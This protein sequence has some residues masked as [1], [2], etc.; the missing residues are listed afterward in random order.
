MYKNLR[1]NLPKE[2][3]AFP[4]F[5]FPTYPESFVHHT[6]V[7]AYLQAYAQHFQLNKYVQFNTKVPLLF[8]SINTLFYLEIKFSPTMEI[9]DKNHPF[10]KTSITS[11]LQLS[12]LYSR[13]C[14]RYKWLFL[15]RICH[16]STTYIRKWAGEVG[17]GVS[18]S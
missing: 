3:M 7:L 17:G 8:S 13:F 2:V 12:M 5:P 4:D 9:L 1:T 11:I 18:V 14:C 10:L 16:I 6:K 15:G